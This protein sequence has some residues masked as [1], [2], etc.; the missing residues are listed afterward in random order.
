MDEVSRLINKIPNKKMGNNWCY[1]F[2]ERETDEYFD[3]I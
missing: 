1:E 3:F 2:E